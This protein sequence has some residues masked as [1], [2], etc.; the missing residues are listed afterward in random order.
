M[1]TVQ[2]LRSCDKTKY[3]QGVYV[4]KQ[5]RQQG[6]QETLLLLALLL[7]CDCCPDGHM[8]L[9]QHTCLAGCTLEL[10]MSRLQLG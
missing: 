8:L 2:Q 10:Y 9:N 7:V 5:Q 1:P 3:M 6:R 4:S